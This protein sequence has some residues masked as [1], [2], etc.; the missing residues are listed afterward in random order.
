MAFLSRLTNRFHSFVGQM[1]EE[2]QRR[3]AELAEQ[4]RQRAFL[5]KLGNDFE[6]TAASMFDPGAFRQIHRTPRDDETNGRYVRDMGYP[7]LRFVENATGRRFWVECKFRAHVGPKWEI[8]W[9]TDEQLYRYKRIR[10]R[11]REPVFIMIGVGGT[12]Q[13]PERIYCLD[14]DRINFTTLFYGTYKR[15]RVY[16]KIDDLDGLLDLAN[17]I[18]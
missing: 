2:L 7:D 18:G 1:R 4:E 11:T 14:L 13:Q 12:V 5:Y 17:R 6:D 16:G 15:N 10:E 8:D 9:C 3:E